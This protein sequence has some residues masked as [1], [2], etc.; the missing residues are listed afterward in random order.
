MVAS[1]VIVCFGQRAVTE[2]CLDSLQRSLGPALGTTWELVLVD[3]ASPDDTLDL[4]RSWEDRATIVA[5]PT[6]RNFSG[7]C[8]AGA[9]AASGE[10]L[11]FLNN[12]T[13]VGPGALEALVEQARVPGVGAVGARLLYPDGTIQHAGVWMIKQADRFV[14]P[15]HLF[16]HEPGDA[17]HAA[18]VVDV[19]C[20]TGACLVMPADGFRALAGFDEQYVNGWED[21]DL[22]L[23]IRSGGQRIV[24]RGDIVI[25][26][27]EGATRGRLQGVT[28]NAAV[29]YA[30]W[31]SLIEDDLPSF[32]AIWGAGYAPPG[33]G[34]AEPADVVVDG[35]MTSLGPAAAHTRAVISALESVGLAPAA[36]DPAQVTIGPRMTMAEWAPAQRACNRWSSDETPHIDPLILS[37]PIVPG[38]PGPGGH[39]VLV[40]LPSHDRALATILLDTARRTGMAI[41]VSPTV[42]TPEVDEF[43]TAGAP[44]ATILDPLTSE[45]MLEACARDADL[46]VAA[47]PADRWDRR[48]LIC[49]G[50]GAAVIV[51]SGGPAADLLEGLAGVLGQRP[52][53]LGQRSRLHAVV[54]DRCAPEHVLAG[55]LNSSA[56]RPTT[57]A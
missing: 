42:R 7:G 44:Q 3:N 32:R 38:G 45:M 25:V 55:L 21:V 16:H 37:T 50:A 31:G 5:L 39:G 52:P 53:P 12:D 34:P 27:C 14:V 9:A 15:Y 17:P 28:P 35:W 8:N 36:T 48:A 46:V 41:R 57:R 47:D 6:N 10:T 54:R 4:L 20:V 40:L 18:A 29:F 26:H 19:D 30:R 13:T 24:Y 1:I 2:A 33:A 23:R 56:L 43:I 11:V 22:C 51:R 49:A